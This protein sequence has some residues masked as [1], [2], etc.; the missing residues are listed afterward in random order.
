MSNSNRNSFKAGD[1]LVCTNSQSCGYTLGS[2][3]VVYQNSKG[4]KC[5]KAD[6]GYEDIV[7]MMVS[8]FTVVVDTNTLKEVK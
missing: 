5:L 2:K 7:S 1:V 6:D 4:W 3:Y 8:S